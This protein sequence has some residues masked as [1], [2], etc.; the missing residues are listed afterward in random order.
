[1]DGPWKFGD[2]D[3][4]TDNICLSSNCTCQD[5]TTTPTNHLQ[6]VRHMKATVNQPVNL[7]L[8]FP[9]AVCVN[10]FRL[11]RQYFRVDMPACVP[12]AALASS[13]VPSAGLS[14]S[15]RFHWTPHDCDRQAYVN[16]NWIF[17]L[18]Q[19]VSHDPVLCLVHLN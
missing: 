18:D 13:T 6:R 17:A 3:F 12:N 11:S 7:L 10:Q 16:R 14:L 2:Y 1:M 8:L 4:T 15:L 19:W 5:L 9:C